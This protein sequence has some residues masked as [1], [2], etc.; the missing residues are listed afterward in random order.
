MSQNSLH[1]H[2]FGEIQNVLSWEKRLGIIVG[3]ARGLTY[4]HEDSNVRIIHRDI[5][6][7]NI[8]LDDRFH[9]KIADFGLARFFPDGE[10]HVSTRVGGTIGYTAPEYAVHGQLTEKADVYSYGIVVLEIV[11]GRKSV[12]ARLDASMQLLLEWA[13]NQFQQDQVLDIVDSSLEGQYPREQVLRVIRI[14]LLCTQGSWALRP[15]MSEVVS[16]LTNNSEITV[17]PTQPAFIDDSAG[18][19]TDFTTPS[20]SVNLRSASSHGSITVSFVPR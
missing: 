20:D 8:L 7:G 12:N 3:T 14:A 18:K 13:W 10:T 5:K 6:C 2:L 19:P 9:P 11:S 1:K 15:A 16:M 17:Q 4:L